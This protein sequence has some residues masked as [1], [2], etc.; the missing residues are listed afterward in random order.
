MPRA[1]DAGENPAGREMNEHPDADK[2]FLCS[3]DLLPINE[4]AEVVKHLSLCAQCSAAVASLKSSGLCASRALSVTQPNEIS[5]KV[6]LDEVYKLDR[7]ASVKSRRVFLIAGAASIVLLAAGLLIVF[8][9]KTEKQQYVENL[10]VKRGQN[11]KFE[12]S[13][14]TLQVGDILKVEKENAAFCLSDGSTIAVSKNT[15]F[16]VKR[17]SE[18]RRG[19]QICLQSGQIDFDVAPGKGTFIIGTPAGTIQVLGTRFIVRTLGGSGMNSSTL[20]GVGGVAAVAVGVVAGT[21]LLSNDSG[22]EKLGKDQVGIMQRGR[23]PITADSANLDK[24][25][26]EMNAEKF[27]SMLSELNALKAENEKLKQTLKAQPK[28]VGAETKPQPGDDTEPELTK[29]KGVK[30]MDDKLK[31]ILGLSAEQEKKMRLAIAKYFTK[32][33]EL[34]TKQLKAEEFEKLNAEYKAQLESEFQAILSGD[35][36]SKLKEHR[37]KKS[38]EKLEAH[39][40]DGVSYYDQLLKLDAGQKAA[41]GEMVRSYYRTNPPKNDNYSWGFMYD[42]AFSGQL[43]GMLNTADQL[44][45]F[46]KFNQQIE[47][48]TKKRAYLGVAP[49][50]DE[51]VKGSPLS[52]VYKDTAA[53]NAGLQAGDVITEIGGIPVN[54]STDLYNAMAKMTPGAAIIV[55]FTRNGVE[56]AVQVVLGEH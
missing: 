26:N 22:E 19:F 11:S 48:S 28:T 55:K 44:D 42:K 16:E 37:A 2:L 38:E 39:V 7:G 31:E 8:K 50:Y 15:I 5:K 10:F 3:Q 47:E 23:A 56:S 9:P 51:N 43:Q 36:Y 46:Q 12:K 18:R 17:A 52:E 27:Q 34:Y 40:N 14:G 4:Q 1:Q 49:G 6:V 41:L 35:Q 30:L 25:A 24:L 20:L 29:W 54:N 21:V 45:K 32:R 33:D 13:D 53:Y